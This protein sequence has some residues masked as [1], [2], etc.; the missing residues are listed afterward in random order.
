MS[1]AIIL[2]DKQKN[3][4]KII[5]DST[6]DLSKGIIEKYNILI[7]PLHIVLGE[8]EYLDGRDISPDEITIKMTR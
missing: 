3:P 5:A 4:L 1:S 2:R 7:A 6:C 8:K